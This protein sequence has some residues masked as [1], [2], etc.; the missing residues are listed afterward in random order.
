MKIWNQIDIKLPKRYHYDTLGNVY[1]NE[2]KWNQ[3]FV[4]V[5]LEVVWFPNITKSQICP[6]TM[7]STTFNDFSKLIPKR[8]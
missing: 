4:L 6:T 1:K 2:I 8:P 3:L 7:K 5:V